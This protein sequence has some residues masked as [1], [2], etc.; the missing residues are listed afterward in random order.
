MSVNL[1]SAPRAVLFLCVGL[2]VATAARGQE[3]RTWTDSTGRFTLLAKFVSLKD[4]QVTLTREDGSQMTIE[5]EKLSEDDQEY[6]DKI[7]AENPFQPAGDSPFKSVAPGGGTSAGSGM[8]R[9][10]ARESVQERMERFRSGARGPTSRA[11]GSEPSVD[12]S[13]APLVALQTLGDAWN[14]TVPTVS[15]PGF[16]PRTVALPE[17]KDFFEKLTGVAINP[18]AK[19]AVVGY[20]L[21]RHREEGTSRIQFCDIE[22]GRTLSSGSAPG[23]MAPLA[24][25]DNGEHVLMR[26]NEFGFG[27]LDRLEIWSLAGRDVAQARVWVPYDDVKGAD[28]DVMWADFLDV[29]TLA[30]AS[31]GGRVALWDMSSME[32]L[33]HF[34]LCKGAVPAVGPN[35]KWIAFCSTDRVGVFDVETREVIAAQ[36]IPTKLTWPHVAFSPSGGKIGCIASDRILVWDTASG[37]LEKNFTTP[38]IHINGGIDFPDEGFILGKNEFLIALDTQLKLWQ[39]QGV[40]HARTI[41]G[42]TFLAVA[43]HGPGALMATSLPHSAAQSILESALKQ[44]D[45]FVFREGT[46]VKLNT[47]TIPA[48]HQQR[49]TEAL[50]KKLQA[51]KCPIQPNAAVEVAATVEGP[52]RKEI[53]YMFTGDYKVQEYRTWVRFVYQ[54]KPIWETSGTNIPMVLMLKDGENVEGALRKASAQPSYGFFDKVVLP[55]FLQ[56]PA[57]DQ[58]A[59]RGQ[60]LGSCRVTGTGFQ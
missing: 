7:G 33:C 60:T 55:E 25:H 27:N 43:G 29:N 3:L 58:R 4:G 32:P 2:V 30:T 18:I 47:S 12:W 46:P 28:R 50:T 23:Q 42:A 19:K 6:V 54:G 39:Y 14:L 38:G 36:D 9:S 24:L 1:L 21:A 8:P 40:Q 52:K 31:R 22:R 44:P 17:K 45:L 48:P 51:M 15:S 57:D 41:G 13:E 37:Q 56:K 10:S 35:R 53:S 26:R 20:T 49:V 5:L 11:R 34:Q 59:G 16:R